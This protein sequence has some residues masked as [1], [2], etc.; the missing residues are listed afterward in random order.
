[1]KVIPFLLLFLSFIVGKAN[2]VSFGA[3]LI[4]D[5][6][7]ENA[8]AVIRYD[9]ISYHLISPGKAVLKRHKVITILNEHAEGL[10][11]MYVLYDRNSKVTS[12]SGEVLDAHG[13]RIRK[14]KKNDI[15]DNSLVGSYTLFQDD[16]YLSFDGLHHSYPY[17]IVS[18]YEIAYDGIVSIN[19]W[20]PIPTYKVSVEKS[21]FTIISEDHQKI[22]F[23]PVNLPQEPE[24]EEKENSTVYHWR[25]INKKALEREPYSPSVTEIFPVLWSTPEKFEFENTSGEFKSWDSFGQWKWN[26]I[27]GR[28][29]VSEKTKNE[30]L[31]L[32]RNATNDKA[33]A[34]LIYEY[35]QNK[36]RYISIQLGIGGWQPFPALVVDEVGY[37]D[38]KALSNY[39]I[40]LLNI[41]GIHS[42]YSVIGNGDSKIKFPD[43]P[44]MGQ[45]NHVIVCVPF[46]SDTTWLECTSQ[47]YPFGYIGTGN[48]D[49]YVLLVTEQGGK[50]VK[51]PSLDKDVNL[52]IRK[53]EVKLD[54]EGNAKAMVST[55][56]SGL[57]YGNRNFILSESKEEQQK[58][59]LKNMDFNSPK[60]NSFRVQEKN[61]N[62]PV[63][64]EELDLFLPSYSTVSGTRMFLKPNLLN[65]FS[66]PPKRVRDRKFPFE[67]EFAYTDIDSVIYTIPDDFVLESSMN[68]TSLDT[69]FGAYSI[70]VK[71][72]ES[73]LV[74]VRKVIMNKGHW[75]AEK[76]ENFRSFL[77]Q[78]Y[79]LDQ[80]KVVFVKK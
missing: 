12:F 9:S 62:S 61:H 35:F 18:D 29:E 33:K 26:L 2:E 46:E 30:V 15:T 19:R 65:S 60:L 51:T 40:A 36:T 71:I 50:L 76:Y 4:S 6:L 11:E 16:R 24:S 25:V 66:R 38:C 13:E 55:E 7:M 45:A 28:Q 23:K 77:N 58:W 44:S 10:T 53:A 68:D 54:S 52:Q 56:F 14:I 17:T 21:V 49:R 43:F 78:M 42:I 27:E 80:G 69:E 59:Y 63:V 72:D 22:N 74:Y 39:M 5:S 1:M 48:N 41:A 75:P 34:R 37:G 64:E 79:K 20:M 57:Q 32:I 47:E 73:S 31:E 67:R 3:S 8:N 70:S